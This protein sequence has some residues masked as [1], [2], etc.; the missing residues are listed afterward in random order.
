MFCLFLPHIYS[1]T[2]YSPCDNNLFSFPLI[3]TYSVHDDVQLCQ[4]LRGKDH[5]LKL[6]DFNRAEIMDYDPVKKEYCRYN[7]GRAYGNVC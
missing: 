4:W 7:N 6:G 1:K 5:K 2:I 3:S